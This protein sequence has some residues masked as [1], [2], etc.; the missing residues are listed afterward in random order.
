MPENRTEDMRCMAKPNHDTAGLLNLT[1]HSV[2]MADDG[3]TC[4]DMTIL[5]MPGTRTVDLGC[6]AKPNHDSKGLPNLTTHS[7]KMAE[8]GKEQT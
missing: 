5:T 8:E 1:T 4:E 3:V 7:V 2:K 6:M